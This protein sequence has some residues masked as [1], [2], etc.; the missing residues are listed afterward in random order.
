[1]SIFDVAI[2]TVLRDEGEF[3]DDPRDA[4]GATK[5]GISFRWLKNV[6][7]LPVELG[8]A[9][10]IDK[11]TMEQLT[12]EQAILLYRHYFWNPHH[13]ER[14]VDQRIATKT[15]DFTVNAGSRA[16]HTCVQWALRASGND[17]V[18]IDGLLGDQT[19]KAINAADAMVL[20]AAF[21]SEMAGYYRA[22]KK[23]HFEA[24][25]LRRAYA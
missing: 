17:K 7:D 9:Q 19:I 2:Q 5:Y 18:C 24:G 16:S 22:L 8:F 14:I 21:R 11:K 3:V 4:G 6:E 15:F 25:W 12:R 13:Y 10:R 1:M 23:P 20:L